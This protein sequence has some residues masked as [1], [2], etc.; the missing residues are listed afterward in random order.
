VAAGELQRLSVC[1]VCRRQ[2]PLGQG[3]LFKGFRR[4]LFA[5]HQGGCAEVVRGAMQTA[6]KVTLAGAEMVMAA[7]AP[8]LLAGLNAL[9]AA[10]TKLREVPHE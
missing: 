8:K 5:V 10:L 9:R 1:L 3:V 2:I 6:G 4:S 7:R